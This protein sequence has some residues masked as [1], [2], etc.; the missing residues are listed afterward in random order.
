MN[1]IK[2]YKL[3]PRY[4]TSKMFIKL[5]TEKP[6]KAKEIQEENKRQREEKKIRTAC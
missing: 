6:S 2:L 1:E 4:K 3:K 5:T